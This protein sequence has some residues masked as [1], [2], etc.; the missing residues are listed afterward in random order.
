MPTK[1][2]KTKTHGTGTFRR[3]RES[4]DSLIAVAAEVWLMLRESI[5]RLLAFRDPIHFM[6]GKSQTQELSANSDL[7]AVA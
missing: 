5:A 6:G 3:N 1:Y 2:P 4:V 7:A